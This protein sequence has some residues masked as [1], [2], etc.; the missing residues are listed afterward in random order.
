M[1]KGKRRD[2][3]KQKLGGQFTVN[4]YHLDPATLQQVRVE[5]GRQ[6]QD[7]NNA[8]AAPANNRSTLQVSV[9]AP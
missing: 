6:A 2:R 9:A 7:R 1:T 5:P 3:K 8:D 4:H